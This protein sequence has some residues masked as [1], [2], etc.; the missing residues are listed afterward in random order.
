[1]RI[2]ASETSMTSAIAVEMCQEK[3]LTN[4]MLRAVGVPVPEGATASSAEEAWAAAQNVGLP[5]VV[6][7]YAGNQGKGVSV[8]L[9]T[10][11]EVRNAYAIAQP[12]DDTVLVERY[13]E[14]FDYRLLVVNG[15]MVAAARR[16]PAQVIG[17]GA[18]TIEQL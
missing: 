13:I 18:R 9:S 1:R 14:G 8:N 10:E 15:R 5:V 12:F 4:G 11:A 3:P 17:D 6:K 16:E 7:P 2:Q